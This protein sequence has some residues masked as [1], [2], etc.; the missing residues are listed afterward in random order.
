[1]CVDFYWESQGSLASNQEKMVE[2]E[3]YARPLVL[4][5]CVWGGVSS[6]TSHWWRLSGLWA[7]GSGQ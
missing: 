4:A 5:L 3:T 6:V 7:V 1:M 2:G